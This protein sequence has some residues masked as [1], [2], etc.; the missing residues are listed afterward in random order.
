[1]HFILIEEILRF[2]ILTVVFFKIQLLT[3]K[4][5]KLL[6]WSSSFSNQ[7]YFELIYDRAV[8][9]SS[10]EQHENLFTVQ[11]VQETRKKYIYSVTECRVALQRNWPSEYSI[12]STMEKRRV[13]CRIQRASARSSGRPSVRPIHIATIPR[14]NFD[15]WHETGNN[16]EHPRDCNPIPRN[17]KTGSN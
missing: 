8:L 3:T 9:N 1:M 14:S 17:E 2:S 7:H 4:Y 5:Q 11:T 13:V 16:I 12:N 15:I 6:V 10:L